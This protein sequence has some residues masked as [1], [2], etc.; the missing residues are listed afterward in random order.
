LPQILDPPQLET[1]QVLQ[2]KRHLYRY[3]LSAWP[4][5]EQ[6]DYIDNW[7]I[8]AI[9]E[10][11]QAVWTGQITQLLINVPPGC[12]KSLIT[13]VFF[14]SWCWANDSTKRFFYASYDQKLST[15]DSVKCRTLVESHWYQQRFPGQV[16]LKHD[17]DQKTY[18]ETVAGGFRLATSI[19]G[20]GTGQHPDFIVLDDPHSVMMAES[21]KERQTALDWWDHTMSTRG[22]SRGVRRIIIMQRLHEEDLSG[23]VLRQGGWDHLCLPMRYGGASRSSTSL[24]FV[25]KRIAKGQLLSET[26]FTEE[27]VTKLETALGPYGSAGQLDQNP[28]PR[29]GGIFK[30]EKIETVEAAPAWPEMKICRYWDTG[31]TDGGGDFTA[32]VLMG[33]HA[34]SGLYYILDVARDQWSSEVRKQHQRATADLDYAYPI[35]HNITQ[36]Q[37][38]EPGSAG[39]DQSADFVKLM[40]GY[41][42]KTIRETGDK[43]VRAD[44]FSSQLNAGNVKIVRGAW[45]KAF[46]DELK[47][48]PNGKNDDQ[49]D[50]CSGAFNW[51]ENRTGK[52]FLP[53]GWK[54]GV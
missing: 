21:A 27:M 7:H 47:M 23:H 45:N 10:H 22:V 42:T 38:E 1:V 35:C 18:Y 48:F 33:K 3:V 2:E 30:T 50:A 9:C 15:R 34:K 28:A 36:I 51:L 44:P 54:F 25:D 8:G 5:I 39:K 53:T 46:I 17:Q 6:V 37:S 20:H 31:A 16:A 11:L 43:V 13:S 4:H 24:G 52:A 26:Q 14:P 41:S 29:S 40:A 32:G 19:G 12:S 49:V